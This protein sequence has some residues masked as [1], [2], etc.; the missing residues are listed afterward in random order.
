MGGSSSSIKTCA[1]WRILGAAR[2]LPRTHKV[3]HLFGQGTF[4]GLPQLFNVNEPQTTAVGG[5][6]FRPS[7]LDQPGIAIK[8]AALDAECGIR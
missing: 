7:G 6:K 8:G 3:E 2:C 5:M 1:H 4:G